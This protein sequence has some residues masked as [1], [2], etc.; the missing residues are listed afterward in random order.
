MASNPLERIIER[1]RHEVEEGRGRVSL[2]DMRLRAM[3]ADPPRNFF[4]AVTTHPT[5]DHW[6]V[7]AEIKRKSPSAGWIREEYRSDDFDPVPFARAYHEAGAVAI[8]CLTDGP[9][10]GGDIDYIRRIRNRVP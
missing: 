7:I 2:E 9:D 10:F 5:P 6:S 4:R 8:S 1:K 3:E